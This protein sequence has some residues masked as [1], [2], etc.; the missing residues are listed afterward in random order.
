MSLVVSTSGAGSSIGS[1]SGRSKLVIV[2]IIPI[3][4]ESAGIVP[5][6]SRLFALGAHL[7][8]NLY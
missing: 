4:Y 2:K 7:P 8:D 1:I 3:G 5:F 6:P